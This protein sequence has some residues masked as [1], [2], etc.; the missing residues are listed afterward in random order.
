MTS[1]PRNSPCPCG[2]GKKF[3][4]CCI[5][6]VQLDK[7]P[8]SFFETA[9][10]K[11]ISEAKTAYKAFHKYNS[12][13]VLKI[14]ALLQFQPKNHGK[15]VR[16]DALVVDTL[17]NI[18]ADA[19]ELNLGQ[20]LKDIQQQCKPSYLEDP[21][22]EF[23]TENIVLKSGNYIVFPGI[24]TNGTEILQAL[25]NCFSHEENFPMEFIK[26][27]EEGI[28]LILHLHDN[29]AKRLAYTHRMFEETLEESLI[30]PS[31]E[32][33][34]NMMGLFSFT[35]ETIGEMSDQLGIA[36]DTFDQFVY[37]WKNK[38]LS[39]SHHDSNPLLQQPFVKVGEEFILVM[40]TSEL[41]C[42]NDFIVRLASK[43]K[44]LDI[45]LRSYSE[46]GMQELSPYFTR[47]HW[48]SKEFSFSESSMPNLFVLLESLW[49]IDTDKLVYITL[50]T[51]IPNKAN[52]HIQIED[53]SAEYTKRIEQQSVLIKQA[54]GHPKLLVI[55]II[56]KIRVLGF[57]G[58]GLNKFK[59]SEYF[60][61][62]S[63]LELQVLTL[64]W[65]FRK[66]SIWK[67]TKYL[68]LAEDEIDFAP[69]NTHYSKYDWY[70]RNEESFSDPD[71]EKINGIGFGFEIEGVNRRKGLSIMD[72]IGIPFLS[73]GNPLYIQ[74]Y[75]KEQYYPVY[76]SQTVNH[77]YLHSCLLK[78]VCPIWFIPGEQSVAREEVFINGILYWLNELYGHVKGF[79]N[80]LGPLPVFFV[81]NIGE[82]YEEKKSV[83]AYADKQVNILY[84][85]NK[86]Q[87]RIDIVIPV[88]IVRYTASPDNEGEQYLM[89]FI[90]DMLG[91]LMHELGIGQKLAQDQLD[92]AIESAIPFGS[93]KM[94][95]TA[96]G[97]RDLKIAEI[98]IDEPHTISKADTSY[99]LEN[100]VKWLGPKFSIPLQI[101]DNKDKH[102]LFN[103]LVLLHFHKVESQLKKYN[104][105]S[106]LYFLMRRNE[107]LI[108]ERSFRKINYPAKLSCYGKY[109]DVYKEFTESESEIN[110]SSLAVRVLIEFVACLMPCGDLEINDDDVDM[111]LAHVG[112]LVSYGSMSD[113][114]QYGVREMDVGL[115]PSGRIGINRS[116]NKLGFENFTN[117]VYG[118]EFDGYTENFANSFYRKN[119]SNNVKEYDAYFHE[120]NNAF[121]MEW[122]VGL[123]D[124][125][126]IS[127]FIAYYLFDNG[128][129][130]DSIKEEELFKITKES[131]GFS[132][133]EL[134]S[135]VNQLTFLQRPN[136]L[137]A[138]EGF[139]KSEIYP[140]RYNRRL[141]YLVR[142]IIRIQK[143]GECILIISA[144]HL[145]LATENLI[146][147]FENGTLKV[148]ATHSLINQIIAKQNSIKGKEFRE[149][150]YEWLVENT[151]ARVIPHEIHISP[152]GFFKETTNLGDIDI[153][154][155]DKEKKIVY[156][157]E[158]KNTYQSK[159]AYEFHLEMKNYLGN[160]PNQKGLIA[161][162]V[163]RDKW[164]Q[165]NKS[166]V[167]AK[168]GLTSEYLIYS[169]VISK[170][171]LPTKFI[172]KLDISLLSFYEL[173]RNGLPGLSNQI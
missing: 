21:P 96:L 17:Q 53:L 62:F 66:L 7:T 142:P 128:K 125:A 132:E 130:I 9:A 105:L 140:W 69:N 120:V 162:H 3:K 172:S 157:I 92:E 148:D 13:K 134:I 108:Q 151:T 80:Q 171:I 29:I 87:R 173:K 109:Y 40:P 113:E 79:V 156:S 43:H 152:R 60:I 145:W 93:Q 155:I 94:I 4:R 64:V 67:Y 37:D 20:L 19:P 82:G 75:R 15:N 165:E 42:L 161:K 101:T 144:R 8:Y 141:S 160:H 72:K 150:V 78:Y 81:V 26:K 65:M 89:K 34:V 111:L 135:Y 118:E 159:V 30:I 59:N 138:P 116:S 23:F 47:M 136:I 28:L 14:L 158:C 63:L 48:E 58:F 12:T 55:G 11:Q 143:G 74:C 22:E 106:L 2:S 153:L 49:Q 35:P 52:E 31:E 149:E 5:D 32:Y 139:A 10:Q 77:G 119:R 83:E 25:I 24:S 86:N 27:T 104:G 99:L 85:I 124:L 168:L 76:I 6:K 147:S 61:F 90:L 137:E 88:E 51:E 170:H 39:F 114:I 45:L 70:V 1:I 57:I 123:Y 121:K 84:S 95:I 154:A 56:H 103:G 18:N 167:E 91:E 54:Y 41:I 38:G 133:E 169:I 68:D 146:G 36:S 46:I 163:N 98:D 50:I 122:G 112:Q 73:S 115:L 33:V 71:K 102:K 100:Q 127:Q 44:C 126:E 16:L 166:E 164:L 131:T 110:Y 97:D 107:T 129:S 117:H